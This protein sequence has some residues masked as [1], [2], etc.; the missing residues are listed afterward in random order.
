[1][2]EVSFNGGITDKESK[3]AGAGKTKKEVGSHLRA[4]LPEG[5]KCALEPIHPYKVTCFIVDASEVLD[6]IAF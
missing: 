1:L 2:P 4:Q 6:V 5:V 3:K